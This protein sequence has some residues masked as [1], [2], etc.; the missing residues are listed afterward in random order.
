MDNEGNF[1]DRCFVVLGKKNGFKCAYESQQIP[2]RVNNAS[3]ARS[4][5]FVNLFYRVFFVYEPDKS[6]IQAYDLQIFRRRVENHPIDVF[7]INIIPSFRI[8]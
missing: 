4:S 3:I 8:L 7:D 6:Q 1:I 2:I 5:H